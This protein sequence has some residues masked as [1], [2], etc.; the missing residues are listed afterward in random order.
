MPQDDTV[1]FQHYR[2]L[3]RDDGHLW[4]L[5]RGAMGVTYK[6]IDTNLESFVALKVINALFLDNESARER[7]IREARAAAQLRHRNVASVYH[8]GHDSQ[9][10]FY[11]MEFIDGETLE[12]LVKRTGPQPWQ[13]ALPIAL[14]V[15]RALMAAHEKRLVHRDIKPANI[16]LVDEVDESAVVKLIDFGLAKSMV[17]GSG[18]LV[19][20]S[21]SGFLG[22]PLYASPEQCDE[23][24]PDIRSDIYSVGVTL[25]YV[26]TSKPPFVGSLGKVFSQHLHSPPPFE[27]LPADVPEAV[28]ALLGRMLAK[29]RAERPQTPAELRREIE[30]CLRSSNAAVPAVVAP[31]RLAALPIAETLP[32]TPASE[33]LRDGFR[34]EDCLRQTGGRLPV[35]LVADLLA[36]LAGIVDAAGSSPL[37]L[38]PGGVWIIPAA[39]TPLRHSTPFTHSWL[40]EGRLGQL[41]I[42]APAMREDAPADRTILSARPA[43]ATPVAA[44]ATL[45]YELLGGAAPLPGRLCRPLAECGEEANAILRRAL[46]GDSRVYTKAMAFADAL[47]A[48]LRAGGLSSVSLPALPPYV[49]TP[50][51]KLQRLLAQGRE[52]M[53]AAEWR[54]AIQAYSQVLALRP[55]SLEALDE[56]GTAY[57]LQG[58][59]DKAKADYAQAILLPLADARDHYYRGDAYEALDQREKAKLDFQAALALEA[60]DAHD[61]FLRGR[62]YNG[63]GKCKSAIRDFDEAIR[64]NPQFAAAFNYRGGAYNVLQK[65]DLAIKDFD[66]AIR[67]SP[68][69]AAAFNNR[70]YA[71]DDLQKRE[72]AIQDF[73]EAIRL[74]PKYA[75]AFYNRGCAYARLQKFDLAIKD[76][77]EAIRLDPQY[78]F[79][80]NNRGI[81]YDSLQKYDLAIQDF[82]EAIRLDAGFIAAYLGRAS[83]YRVLGRAE[84]AKK[85]EIMAKQLENP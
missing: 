12:H 70:G 4:E 72:S 51:D 60:R 41:K 1:T 68:R 56:R 55:D 39:D 59:S 78:A 61:F 35:A 2:V 69:F 67:L 58:E 30:T 13:V 75:A 77:T 36:S 50:Q 80:F 8:L 44:L 54:E 40:T 74:N 25:W 53:A 16:M 71:Y 29:E 20:L 82:T 84:N 5:G 34:L 76:F 62:A 15:A 22:T 64:L 37:D 42:A 48:E 33:T 43:P 79:A 49:K 14:Q 19:N 38:T 7:F 27:R 23:I 63:L 18:S 46:A 85:D 17:E 9:S 32:E 66:E 21:G 10:F 81:A 83:A 45:L 3:R 6:A 65:Y 26:L 57:G 73:T 28:R 31:P 47:D 24:A 11:A 52:F